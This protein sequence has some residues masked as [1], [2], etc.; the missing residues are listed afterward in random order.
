MGS[1]H[2]A[3]TLEL[4]LTKYGGCCLPGQC[5]GAAPSLMSGA[6]GAVDR[7]LATRTLTLLRRAVVARR[8]RRP[9][10]SGW[11]GGRARA[12]GSGVGLAGAGRAGS[13][14]EWR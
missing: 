7:I 8:S 6:I 5:G 4:G 2:S 13:P 10:A 12:D 14:V 11:P 9:R 1:Y 3:C